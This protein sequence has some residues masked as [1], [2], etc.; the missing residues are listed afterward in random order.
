[1]GLLLGTADADL[2]RRLLLL[3]V[4]QESC[5]LG[6]HGRLVVLLLLTWVV[7]WAA[8]GLLVILLLID[9]LSVATAR[10]FAIGLLE[11]LLELRE[12]LVDV[13]VLLGQVVQALREHAGVVEEAG[14]RSLVLVT[15]F[16][17][18]WLASAV[19]VEPGS[20]ARPILLA[21]R[22]HLAL[23]Q[24]ATSGHGLRRLAELE[25][26]VGTRL[27]GARHLVRLSSG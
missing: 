19:E 21:S 13:R 1:M 12:E 22:R 10:H 6:A 26:E 18:L 23:L 4:L 2:L 11:G 25:A 17:L 8:A 14:C 24:F 15:D 16:I 5:M 7:A 27:C 9:D 20:S 3:L